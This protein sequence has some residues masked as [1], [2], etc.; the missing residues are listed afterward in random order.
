MQLRLE[1]LR[2]EDPRADA[3]EIEARAVR[4]GWREGLR[5]LQRIGANARYF[6]DSSQKPPIDVA[7]GN[8]A[9]GLCIDF[10][11]RQQQEAVRRRDRSERVGYVS[12]AGGSAPSVD[13]VAL[14]RGA[15]NRVAAVAFIEYSVA[16][17]GQKLWS[18]R[19]GTPGGPERFALR[20]LPVRRD[21]YGVA[22]WQPW[23]SDPADAPYAAATP[24]VYR[25]AWTGGLFREM[26][27]V[28]RVMCQET[29]GELQRAW[30]SIHAAPES[31][32]ARAL[33]ALQDLAEVDYDRTA[34]EIRTRLTAKSR[35]EEV[36]LAHEL[37]E[38][39]RARYRRAEGI[40]QAR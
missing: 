4:E 11:G 2:R 10:Y 5:L 35:V 32:K 29:H 33:A 22:E 18:F 15:K 17:E 37:A 25:E 20:R 34:G 39:F 38:Q 16:V 36:R 24:L 23:L 21:C 3:G 27:F 12:P 13:P 14:L 40:A 31:A 9:V 30:R 6:T 26:A 28:I 8:C 19:P 1:A 7:S